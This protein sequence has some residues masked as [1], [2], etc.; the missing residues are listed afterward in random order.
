MVK[1]LKKSEKLDLILS[2]L[3][4]LRGE[5][6]K[7][8]RDRAAIDEQGVRAKPKP[9]RRGPKQLPKR[10]GA[11]KKRDTDLAPSRP[12]LVQHPEVPHPTSRTAPQ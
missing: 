12:V 11:E 4:K 10:S 6:K 3:S 7:L 1:K 2:E 5:V 8:I 9:A